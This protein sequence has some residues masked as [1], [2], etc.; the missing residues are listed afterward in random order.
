MA[1]LP[2]IPRTRVSVCCAAKGISTEMLGPV[3]LDL[4]FL[5][6]QLFE[7]SDGTGAVGYQSRGRYGVRFFFEKVFLTESFCFCRYGRNWPYQ[8]LAA[9]EAIIGCA[10]RWINV[11][12]TYFGFFCRTKLAEKLQ[13]EIGS[14][15]YVSLTRSR[16]FYLR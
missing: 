10:P 5:L 3:D 16:L 15:F 2:A 14:T 8:P 7:T 4:S 13:V 6:A 11:T 12:V 9:G 1:T